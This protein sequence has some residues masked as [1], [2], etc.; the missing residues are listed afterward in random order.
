[1]LGLCYRS[2][3]LMILRLLKYY[4]LRTESYLS[5]SSPTCVSSLLVIL[6]LFRLLIPFKGRARA[7]TRLSSYPA[8]YTVSAFIMSL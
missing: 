4:A 2:S 1:M 5:C 8:M 3:S 6:K 7:Y